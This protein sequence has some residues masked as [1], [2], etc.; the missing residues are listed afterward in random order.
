MLN[1]MRMMTEMALIIAL[2]IYQFKFGELN[3]EY[4]QWLSGASNARGKL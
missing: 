3:R 4:L 2:F 1:D